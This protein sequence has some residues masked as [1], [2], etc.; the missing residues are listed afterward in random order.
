MINVLNQQI[1]ITVPGSTYVICVM[2]EHIVK[3]IVVYV[4]LFVEHFYHEPPARV[5]GQP[6]SVQF[7]IK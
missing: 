4:L 5:I 6:Y 3:Y 7:D 2:W 1:S